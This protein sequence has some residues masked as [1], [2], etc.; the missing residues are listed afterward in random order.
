MNTISDWTKIVFESL[1]ELGKSIMSVLPN[2]VGA[3]FL[4]LL[5]WFLAKLFSFLVKRG[6]KIIGFD[7]I[8]DKI[9]L[10]DMF[11]KVKM[12]ITP[13][14]LVARFVYWIILLIFFLTASD[15]L[16]WAVVSESIGDL[17][18]YLP[19]L[20][21]GIIIFVIGLYIANFIKRALKGVFDSLSVVS[22]GFISSFAFYIILIII[23]LTAIKQAGVDTN[24]ITSNI[25]IILGGILLAFAISFGIGSRTVLSNILSS[26]YTRNKFKSGQFIEIEDISGTIELIDKTSC[27]IKTKDGSRMVIP[28]SKLLT[29]N[30]KIIK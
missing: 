6:L 11:N 14:E 23:S 18:A 9:Q 7:K 19:K 1:L 8:S 25:S 20:F 12:N 29:E 15:T 28:V 17:I 10:D 26:F 2:I 3:L 5:G 30:V 21:S 16:G 4:I 24:I 27:I 22:G 13:S